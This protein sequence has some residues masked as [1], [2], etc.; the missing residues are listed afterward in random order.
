MFLCST[1][2]VLVRRYCLTRFGWRRIAAF[3]TRRS[4]PDWLLNRH[5]HGAIPMP[6]MHQPTA[7]LS[8]PACSA[9]WQITIKPDTTTGDSTPTTSTTSEVDRLTGSLEGEWTRCL[10]TAV[11]PTT[12][13]VGSGL[14]AAMQVWL[15]SMISDTGQ[16]NNHTW[17]ELSQHIYRNLRAHMT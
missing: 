7:T 6:A 4:R 9:T 11:T 3:S 15:R 1:N 12:R 16:L 10:H 14:R 5:M 2:P 13:T 8:C 17:Q